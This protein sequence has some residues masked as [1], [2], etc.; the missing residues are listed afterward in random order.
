MRQALPL[1]YAAAEKNNRGSFS[2]SAQIWLVMVTLLLVLTPAA[3]TQDN[4]TITGFVND[5]SG[6][7][8]PNAQ[9]SI[10]NN[11]TNQIRETV[12]NATGAYRFA[13]VGVGTY[14]LTVVAPGFQKYSKTGVEV[15]V[16]QTIE[17]RLRRGD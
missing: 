13:N 5:Q 16:A 4:A 17:H 9:I 7:V 8:V 12:S 1:P 15:N 11:A 10:T 2:F 3:W 14:T 6:A